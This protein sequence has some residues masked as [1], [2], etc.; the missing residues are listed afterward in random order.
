MSHIIF[1]PVESADEYG[2]LAVGG[3]LEPETL[4]QAYSS[5]IFPWPI[6][7]FDLIPWFSPPK[8]AIL[9]FQSFSLNKRTI[10]HLKNS[11]YR[12]TC[13]TLFSEVMEE[14]SKPIN[15]KTKDEE[16]TNSGTW[17]TDEMKE[18]YAKLHALGFA[19]SIEVHHEDQ[20][21]GGVYGVSLGK[22]FAAESM[23][24]RRTNASKGALLA[25]IQLLQ[26]QGGSFIDCQEMNP[27]LKTLGVKNVSR[28][29]FMNMLNKVRSMPSFQFPKGE[30]MVNYGVESNP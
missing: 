24:Y 17:I 1:P 4:L 2:I 23:F 30:I 3:D 28:D 8:R 12:Y 6:P 10:R 20:L 29:N 13:D 11:N 15:R 16:A 18:A 9:N 7:E 19:H 21:V 22:F 25:L 27:Y 14:C 5:G 26:S